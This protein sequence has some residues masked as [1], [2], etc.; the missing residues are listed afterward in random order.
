MES[1][2]EYKPVMIEDSVLLTTFIC[3]IETARLLV[4]RTDGRF[5]R[6]RTYTLCAVFHDQRDDCIDVAR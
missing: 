1:L 5:A 4:F 6:V 3:S 2:S